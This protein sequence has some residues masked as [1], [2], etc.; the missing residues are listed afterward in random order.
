MPSTSEINAKYSILSPGIKIQQDRFAKQAL[1]KAEK[2]DAEK[3]VCFARM[4]EMQMQ[5]RHFEEKPS[6]SASKLESDYPYVGG[7]GASEVEPV[8]AATIAEGGEKKIKKKK[9]DEPALTFFTQ[10]SDPVTGKKLVKPTRITGLKDLKTL[11]ALDLNGDAGAKPSKLVSQAEEF[12]VEV[13]YRER[14]LQLQALQYP[15]GTE[16]HD[17]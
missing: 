10:L 9:N 4:H 11:N 14:R 8:H 6:K 2:S 13:C 16:G 5:L 15:L 12:D 3:Q 1:D 7:S 17:S